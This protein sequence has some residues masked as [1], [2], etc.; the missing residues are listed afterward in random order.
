MLVAAFA[1]V[2]DPVAFAEQVTA[3]GLAGIVPATVLVHTALALEVGLGLLM[4]LQVRRWWV[5]VPSTALTLFFLFLTGRAYWRWA[6]GIVVD[7]VSCGC[8]GNLVER[9][10]AEA[11]WQD[12]VVLAVPLGLA[13]AV[14]S[15][16][17]FPAKRVA[18]TVAVT[19]AA[20][21]VAAMAPALPLDDVATR[22]S[23]GVELSSLCA[24][25]AVEICLP[26]LAPELLSSGGWVVLLD[27]A[28]AD[29]TQ[30]D[31]LNALAF[32]GVPVTVLTEAT[33]EEIGAFTWRWGPAF[34]VREVPL[35][36]LRPMY[37]QRPRSFSVREGVVVETVAG[38]PPAAG[39][40][41]GER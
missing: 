13:M 31:L 35:P 12:L 11:F 22:V 26:D 4:L 30:I 32:D 21:G 28:A 15:S 19:A 10:P 7:E 34:T 3:E 24:S 39:N 23:P 40:D 16:S 6:N 18:L 17:R 37:R 1:K 2:I 25:G 33:L 5:L 29:E 36:L 41:Q 38:L 14:R 27:L 8:F 9:T 20:L